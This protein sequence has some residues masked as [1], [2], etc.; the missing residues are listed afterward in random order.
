MGEGEWLRAQG[1]ATTWRAAKWERERDSK[2]LAK[3]LAPKERERERGREWETFSVN[4]STSV[5]TVGKKQENRWPTTIA[6][7]E[8]WVQ[9]AGSGRRSS[10]SN[11]S[12]RKREIWDEF[13]CQSWWCSVFQCSGTDSTSSRLAWLNFSGTL[14][15]LLAKKGKRRKGKAI[16]LWS[17]IVVVLATTLKVCLL[18]SEAMCVIRRHYECDGNDY[19]QIWESRAKWSLFCRLHKSCCWP[20]SLTNAIFS[21]LLPS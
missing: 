21:S 7:D 19:D 1:F 5:G 12:T 14:S 3:C 17:L 15:C 9:A 13:I 20:A 4:E 6:G 8:E 2:L 18:A 16:V 10:S 11:G